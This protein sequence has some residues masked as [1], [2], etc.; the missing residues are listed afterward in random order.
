VLVTVEVP[1][2]K[3]IQFTK[4]INKYTWYN[5]NIDGRRNFYFERHWDDDHNYRSN[6]EY[7]MT[8]SG[9]KNPLDSTRKKHTDDE[10][11]DDDDDN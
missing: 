6:S 11:D 5:I 2:G 8:A 7:I 10:D 3:T 1:L 9:L 4:D